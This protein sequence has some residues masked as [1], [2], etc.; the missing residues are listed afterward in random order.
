MNTT[1]IYSPFQEL[2]T[3]ELVSKKTWNPD[4]LKKKVKYVYA[5]NKQ[6]IPVDELQGEIAILAA[7]VEGFVQTLISNRLD[8]Y[9]VTASVVTMYQQAIADSKP[10]E[11]G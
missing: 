6:S 8:W 9:M 4:I 2:I 11:L 1:S 7:F 3:A 5:L 10:F